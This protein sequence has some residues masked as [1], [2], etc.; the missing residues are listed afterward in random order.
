[1]EKSLTGIFNTLLVPI[2]ILDFL[3]GIVGF[4]WLAIYG[5]WGVIIGGFLYMFLSTFIISILLLPSLL[6]VAPVAYFAERKQYLG[7]GIFGLLNASY[8]AIIIYFTCAWM[9]QSYTSSV[10]DGNSILPYLL[11]GYSIATAPWAYMASKEGEEATGTF[12]ALFLTK[13]GLLVVVISTGFLNVS[14]DT[15]LNYFAFIMFLE[16]FFTAGLTALILVS[17]E[18]SDNEFDET[19][20]IIDVEPDLKDDDYINR[21]NIDIGGDSSILLVGETGTGKSELV[22]TLLE[23]LKS[24]YTQDEVNFVLFDLKQVEFQNEGVEYLYKDVITSVVTG[25]RVLREL[26]EQADLRI[27]K[28]QKFPAIVVYIEECDIAAKHQEKFDMLM[29][30]LLDKAKK[31]NFC[32]I[33][34]TSRVSKETVGYELLKHFE[35]ILASRLP[36]G[37]IEYLGIYDTRSISGY[38]FIRIDNQHITRQS[39]PKSAKIEKPGVAKNGKKRSI[40]K[41]L[42]ENNDDE[43]SDWETIK[44]KE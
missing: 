29:I 15:S 28:K 24:S 7:L 9:L 26:V 17:V 4:I 33:Y 19:R 42:D 31:A 22:H 25:V 35:I 16:V 43:L 3:G 14:L 20:D 2:L 18:K 5:E 23:Q 30:S 10:P 39:Q 8:V 40:S 36:M 44:D 1:M 21:D 11:W 27:K 6:L 41:I 13:L 38:D 37:S 32:I 34:S 12:T